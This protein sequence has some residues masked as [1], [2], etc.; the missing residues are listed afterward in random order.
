V[1]IGL[2]FFSFATFYCIKVHALEYGVSAPNI[3]SHW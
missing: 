1:N 3:A 2:Y